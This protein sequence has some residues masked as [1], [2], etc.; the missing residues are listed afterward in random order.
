MKNHEIDNDLL[1]AIARNIHEVWAEGKVSEGWKYGATRDDE[2]KQTPCLV[3]YEELSEVE[4]EYDRRT[5]MAT[6][7]SLLSLGYK[8]SKK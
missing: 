2:H 4:K 3:P 6:I 5:A 1:E 8:I 7:S